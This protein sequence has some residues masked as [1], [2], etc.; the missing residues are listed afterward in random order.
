MTLDDLHAVPGSTD[1]DSLLDGLTAPQREAV[2][3]TEGPL[4]VLAA[5]GSG[6]TRVITRRIAYLVSCG[7]PPWS[8]LALTFTNKAAGEMRERVHAVLG[9][10]SA[11]TRGL[12]VTTFHSLCAR[13]LR[14]YADAAGL[15]PE[16]TIYDSGDQASLCKKVLEQ[17]QLA[18]S[19]WPPRS[20]LSTI[21]EAKN[22]LWD[23]DDYAA[24]AGD[25]FTKTIAKIYSGY[26]KALRAAN[27][28]DFDDLLVLTAKTLRDKP[29][30][31][32]ELRRRW[33]YLLIDEYQDTNHAQFVIASML[34]GNGSPQPAQDH[35]PNI[36]VVGDPDQAI[37]AWRGADITNILEFEEH[38][39]R[40]R[41][42]A[43]GENFRSTAPI[44][45][46][47]DTLIKHN[48]HRKDK[49]LFTSRTGGEKIE[50]IYTRD[51][52]HEA[53][54]VVDWFRELHM[55]RTGAGPARPETDAVAWRD[56]A[57]F[58]RTNALSRVM[59][60]A[61]RAAGIPYTI[62]R[63][64]AFYERE[65]IKNALAYLRIVANPADEVSLSRIANTPTR[66][67][68]DASLEKMEA[69]AARQGIPML[70]AMRLADE[71][72][73][74]AGRAAGSARKFIQMID[75][76]TGGGEF[77]GAQV[78][79]SLAELV[80]RIIKESGLE[81]MYKAQ[82]AASK[83]ES[84]EERLDNL[85]ELISSARQFELEYDPA[86]DPALAAAPGPGDPASADDP[87]GAGEIATPPLLALLR[88]YLESVSLVAD[89]DAVDP[90]QG[91][92]TLMTLHAAKGL[93]FP[94]VAIIGLEEG[95][96]PHARA[97]ES[98]AQLEEER[99][100]CFVG[101][102]RSMRHLMMTSA[103]YRTNRGIP[104]RT[105][106]SRFLEELG[107]GNI[108][109][110]DQADVLSGL[111]DTAWAGEGRRY[112]PDESQLDERRPPRAAKAANSPFPVGSTVRHPQF[113]EGIVVTVSAGLDA[114]ATIKF[115]TVGTKTLVL[116]Y[117]RLQRVR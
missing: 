60:D 11:R 94:A 76:W 113:G 109:I 1:P 89:A 110:S 3:C 17:L 2:L 21:S 101:I 81:S 96:L 78:P 14:R 49:P 48:K 65:E 24:R 50:V 30:V 47:A 77:M 15:K 107:Q 80:E 69:F 26:Q 25:F 42:I 12:T 29:E 100:L 71:I 117:A 19:N 98:E 83:S 108:T 54:L 41:V 114:R 97:R 102:T 70:E 8:I 62:A 66:G 56:M 32:A 18:T 20:V 46:A 75:G 90:T 116:E 58:Y 87:F 61:F 63:G 23:A 82:A 40:A 33:Q 38:Y 35:A 72:P 103:R 104:E 115:K 64:T 43:L 86:G 34:A 31:T 68:G 105:I 28:V 27:A 57:I 91:A 16:F 92:V 55:G 59:E 93:E 37:Y 85:D 106:P 84:D 74:L 79:A 44:L 6:K 111:E 112:V 5:A 36:C 4:L 9:E 99:R 10:G 13:L 7:V 88:G 22:K 52:R 51:E 73:G 45:S 67:L 95:C 39:P 53:D